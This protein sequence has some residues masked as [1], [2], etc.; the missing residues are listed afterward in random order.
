MLKKFVGLSAA[1]AI[2]LTALPAWAQDIEEN[3][4]K[5]IPYSQIDPRL[6]HPAH[7][8]A[9]ITLKAMVRRAEC[10]HYFIRWDANLNNDY[11]DDFEFRANRN[12][13]ARAVFDIGRNYVVP[14]VQR[15]RSQNINVQVRNGCTGELKFATFRI[16]IY[17]FQ[18]SNDSRNWTD[19]QIE[20]MSQMAIQESLWHTHRTMGG[21]ERRDHELRAYDQYSEATGLSLWQMTI[22]GHLPAYPPESVGSLPGIQN[23]RPDWFDDNSERWHNDPYAE[24]AMRYANHMAGS[25]GLSGIPGGEEANTCG[26]NPNGTERECQRI[27][28]TADNRGAYA[29]GSTNVYRMGVN[30]GGLAT[31]LPALAGTYISYGDLRG[32]AWEYYIQQ[33]ADKLGAQQIDGGCSR[34]GWIY[35]DY[36]GSA[37]CN[38]SDASTTQW[39]YIGLESAEIAGGPYGVF[40]NN[41]HKYRIADNLIN[42]QR[43]DGGAGYRSSSGRGDFKLT[44]GS[45][46][47][48]RWLG[49]HQFNT[50]DNAVAFGAGHSGF[51]RSRLRQ[52]YNEYV[53]HLANNWTAA[54]SMGS[55]WADSMW[56]DG[57]YLCGS[58]NGVYNVSRCGST[59]A[60]YSLQK[61]FR[62]GTPEL[63]EI[64][65]RDWVRQFNTYY[66]RAMDRHANNA[67]PHSNYAEHGRIYDTYC[68]GHSVTCSYG[69]GRLA[70][71]M[72]GLVLT[73]SIFNPKPVAIGSVAPEVVTEGCAGGNN[74]LVTFDH[75]GSFHPNPESRIVAY[76]WDVNADDGLWWDGD[77]EPDFETPDE[78]DQFS[79]TFEFRYPTVGT[80]TA[81][82]QVVDNIGQIK[83]S[84]VQVTVNRAEN[85]APAAA[86]GGPYVL[87]S[88]SDLELNG[89]GTDQNIGC[90]DS[91]T[92]AWDLDN[93]GQFD[94]AQGATPTVAWAS[95]Q[96]LQAGAPNRVRVQV[97]D[98][99]GLVATA[100]TML[101]IYPRDPVS[102]G[103]AQPNPAACEQDILFDGS[104]S[105][106]PNPQRSIAQYDWDVD[107]QPGFD[108]AG[109]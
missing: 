65:G 104:P 73:P 66:L 20:V 90:G 21:I 23:I 103:R 26:Y 87:E 50:N 35:G 30:L 78:N 109:E 53:A 19:E 10:G 94:D 48:A 4:V 41:R 107:G 76:R 34:G 31:V 55:H 108:G 106:H 17:A 96:N 74:G 47:G 86:H 83:Q 70:Q 36:D 5:P 11:T 105:F 82:L 92:L 18:P 14:T 3:E 22:N 95:I 59:Y 84:T 52:S 27:G 25:G 64:G 81:T 42:N 68:E 85:V 1:I 69:G 80:F 46:V 89:A 8:G 13:T 101:T 77:G 99:G 63:R 39:A 88:G 2:L 79:E 61:G 44:G 6:P 32:Q 100:E 51:T 57:D 98:E 91:V 97:R 33:F 24:T 43:G 75:S 93:D 12:D 60:M 40:V 62:T 45:L 102:A 7:S 49:I 15:D 56:Q 37:A 38:V 67:D 58:P 9:R 72:G 16:Y 28:G 54:R 71:P 29:R